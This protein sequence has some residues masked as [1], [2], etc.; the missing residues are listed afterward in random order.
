MSQWSSGCCHVVDE[1]GGFV[2][3]HHSVLPQEC[4]A[5]AEH[6]PLA[7]PLVWAWVHDCRVFIRLN[8]SS[9]QFGA[10]LV[11]TLLKRGTGNKVYEGIGCNV[12]CLTS[13]A[14]HSSENWTS[15]SK[16][17]TMK[18]CQVLQDKTDER[19]QIMQSAR[20]LSLMISRALLATFMYWL[21]LSFF[22]ANFFNRDNL[23]CKRTLSLDRVNNSMLSDRPNDRTIPT[24][25]V[26]S[27][28]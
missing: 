2:D 17:R 4:V 8:N 26:E 9:K 3:D 21:H 7:H 27:K 22:F 13:T 6:L 16:Y 14:V 10:V 20:R 18:K 24:I 23:I 5:Q 19:P 1:G 12:F 15:G 25:P 28:R 11:T